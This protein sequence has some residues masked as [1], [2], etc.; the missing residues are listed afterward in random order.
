MLTTLLR[1]TRIACLATLVAATPVAAQAPAARAPADTAASGSLFTRT[2]A[3][4]AGGTVVGT[5]ALLAADRGITDEMRDAGAQ[6][7]GFLRGAARTFDWVGEPGTVVLSLG[8]YGTG[9]LAH[10]PHLAEL[11][12]RSAEALVVSGALTELLKGVAGRQRPFIDTRDPDDFAFG[13]GFTR[14]GHTSFPSGHATAAFAVASVAA[15]ELSAWHPHASRYLVPLVYGGASLVALSRVYGAHHWSSDVVAGAGI[16][17]LSGLLVVR[18][19][20]LHPRSRFDR[21]LLGVHPVV[22]GDR[23]VGLVWRVAT[24]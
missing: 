5:V 21:V 15:T 3:W 6:R 24:R 16:G 18:F 2:D 11:G 10:H 9:R 20:R 13:A 17:T 1:R 14:A 7:S 4:I 8:M 23:G 22:T 12:L 19:H